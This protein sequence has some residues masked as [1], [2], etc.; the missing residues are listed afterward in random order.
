MTAEEFIQK[1]LGKVFEDKNGLIFGDKVIVCGISE[2]D[3]ILGRFD[4]GGWN[5]L[6]DNIDIIKIHS[7]MI[8][9]Y[10]YL[11]NYDLDYIDKLLDRCYST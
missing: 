11:F 6:T 7:P 8:L 4:N 1:H 9:S 3:I 10:A 2:N 5:I